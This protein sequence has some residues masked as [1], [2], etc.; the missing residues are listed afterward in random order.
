MT[1][2]QLQPSKTGFFKDKRKRL[3]NLINP[4]NSG[5]TSPH[6]GTSAAPSSQDS[7]ISPQLSRSQIPSSSP[8][9]SGAAFLDRYNTPTQHDS[10]SFSSIEP[11]GIVG[12]LSGTQD[13]PGKWTSRARS[14]VK[15]FAGVAL[16]F[17]TM[18]LKRLP[19]AVD[20]NPT[21]IAAGIIKIVLQIKDEVKGNIDAVDRRILSTVDQLRAVEEA[22]AGWVPY[23]AEEQQ[24]IRLFKRTLVNEWTNLIRLKEQSLVRRVAVHEE[25]KGQIAASFERI[26]Q[27]REQLVVVTGLRV[28][29]TVLAIQDDLAK[30]LLERLEASHAADHKYEPEG[31]ER[32]LLRRAVC[33]PGTRVGI[34]GNITKWANNTSSESQ[35][36]YWLFG[37]AGSGKSTIAYT[38]A[39]RFEFATD[40][41]DTIVLG[42]NFFC[43]RQIKETRSATRIIRTIVYHLALRCKAFADA[44]HRSGKFNAVHQSVRAQLDGLLIEPWEQAQ[45]T[46]PQKPL[47]FLIIIDALDE[48]DGQ[49][50]SEFLRDLLDSINKHRLRGLKFFA[51]SRPDPDLV[52]H[53]NSFEDKQFYRLEQ[54]P[55]D[56]AE[57]DIMTYL[58]ANL[59]YFK[60]RKEM[61]KLVRQAAGLF[62]Y[63]ATVVKYLA[64]FE[65]LEQQ[66]LMD[67]LPF[68]SDSAI[69]QFSEGATPLLDA[70]YLQILWDAFRPFTSGTVRFK[71]RLQILYTFLCTAERPSTSLVAE[72]LFPSGENETDLVFS[73]TRIADS[74][75]A[76]LHAV[77]YTESDRVLSYHKSF[78]DFL[79]NQNRAKEFWCDPVQHHLLL[80]SSC[81]RVM[82][83]LRFNIANIESSFL[84]DRDNPSLPYA[85]E[86]NISPALRYSCRNWDYHLSAVAL[87]DSNEL[88]GTLS[89]FL[90]LRVLFWIEAM[91]LLLSRGL[92]EQMLRTAHKWVTE[93]DMALKEDLAEAASFALYFSGSEAALSTPHLYVS[94]L[95]TWGWDF[96]LTR[97]WRSHFPRIPHFSNGLEVG[98]TLMT[99]KV[100]STVC[101]VA[102]SS[103]DRHIVSGSEDKIVRVWDSST[104]EVLAVLEGHT[105][106]VN[107]VS[108]ASDNRHIISGSSDKS[109]RV[110]DGLTGEMLKVLVGHTDAVNSSLFSS[111]NRF[112]ISGSSDK[113]VCVWDGLTGGIL[114]V[115]KGHAASVNSVAF[116]SNGR[117]IVS[118]SSDQSVRLWDSSTG[119]MLEVLEGHTEG[120]NSVAFSS[121]NRCIV[122][123]SWDKSVRVWDALTGKI[124][125]VMEGHTEGVDSVAFSSDNRRIVSGSWDQ[126]VRVWNASTGEMLKMLI[127]HMCVKSVAFS[128]D[129]RRIIS[130]SMDRSVRVWDGS[131]GE[132]L[133]AMEGHTE[134]VNS[135]AFSS[136]NRYIVSGSRDQSVRVWDATTGKMLKV[137]EG[138]TAGINSV[139][140]SSDNRHIIS[141]SWDK[142][143]RVW[144]ASTGKTLKVLESHAADVWDVSTGEML[145]ELEGHIETVNS[146]AFSSDDERI[147]T[148]SR[149][150]SVLVWD[151]ST[152]DVLE[153]LEGH[154][155]AVNSVAFSSDD[156]RIVSGSWD[157]SVRVW[158]LDTQQDS[159]SYV[160]QKKESWLGEKIPTGWLLSPQ[161]NQY[162]MFVPLAAN[163]PD[164]SNILT[165]PRSYAPSVD[166]TAST[167]GPEWRRCFSPYLGYIQ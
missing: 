34:L 57:D 59:P 14:T 86:K 36:V 94:A 102:I 128:S 50:G 126:S 8:S 67:G 116:S 29:K 129:D 32:Q 167:L 19:D 93:D 13:N 154:T 81:F 137:L 73:H 84:F 64:G 153:V 114:M 132:R 105:D 42:G 49:G 96:G 60:G 111:D 118:G 161:K 70:L 89:K 72:L 91:N 158:A 80:A 140:F 133:K 142:S 109:I 156:R 28:R 63:A 20:S 53:L 152:G 144:D 99:L 159:Y 48:I 37:Q 106:C 77:L 110:W 107:S 45:S 95:A 97:G 122:S 44:L 61:N 136:D 130:G 41:D 157:K 10:G 100:G 121:D 18:L 164:P 163:L 117:H 11:H 2:G 82:D 162:L 78:T 113:T 135:V 7:Q 83:R 108:F 12:D 147:V 119:K 76:S 65:P 141:G 39:R 9:P 55:T 103:D 15:D 143:V 27:A 43:S 46:N 79:F 40:A 30:L 120:V 123:C 4:S 146:V 138:H 145:E 125:K 75:L 151:A 90:R 26:N 112:V 155:E 6:I 16:S 134:S 68:I 22:L 87:S 38:I 165:L 71:R 88:R 124:Q 85:V 31:E 52:T 101:T 98:M 17:T 127:G 92:C 160:R 149:D 5:S 54:V 25:D 3:R 139:A 47:H 66:E 150:K 115:L 131:T 58:N 33:T 104:G 56:E 24:S 148:G 74:V 51:T 1:D 69:T 23:S 62:I 21:K 35:S 166:F